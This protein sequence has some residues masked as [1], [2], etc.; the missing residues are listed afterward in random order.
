VSPPNRYFDRALVRLQTNCLRILSGEQNRLNRREE[1]FAKQADLAPH[2]RTERLTKAR[3]P[4]LQPW[5]ASAQGGSAQPRA[6]FQPAAAS[7]SPPAKTIGP[8]MYP[9]RPRAMMSAGELIQKPRRK[10]VVTS[11]IPTSSRSVTIAWM[12]G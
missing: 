3:L 7:A 11:A 10:P 12:G 6:F 8:P 1:I 4:R 5:D 9:A 2:P